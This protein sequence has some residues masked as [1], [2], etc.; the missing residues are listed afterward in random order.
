MT[1]AKLE[2]MGLPLAES[3]ALEA[4]KQWCSAPAQY[5]QLVSMDFACGHHAGHW[6]IYGLV[7]TVSTF[8]Q[9]SGT[10]CRSLIVM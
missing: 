4:A 6:G 2:S 9:S 10:H 7:G 5:L 8:F 3:T 1:G